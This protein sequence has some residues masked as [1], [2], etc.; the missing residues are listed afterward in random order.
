[1]P[2][3]IAFGILAC[4]ALAGSS[5]CSGSLNGQT[6][7]DVPAEPA[8]AS[9][10][11]KDRHPLAPALAWAKELKAGIEHNVKDYTAT[12]VKRERNKGK[13]GEE[14]V[15]NVKIRQQPFSVYCGVVAPNKGDE[16]IYLEGQNDGKM[17]CH[18]TGLIGKAFGTR[19]L[20]PDHPWVMEGQHYPITEIGVLNLCRRLIEVAEEDLKYD[21]CEV[22]FDRQAKLNNRSCTCVEV[23][24]PLP[25]KHFRFHL[26]RIYVDNE[27]KVPIRFEAFDW[28][29]SADAEPEMIESYEYRDLKLNVGL[30][31]ADFDVK[32]PEYQFP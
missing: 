27:L 18:T 24:H 17:I 7:S 15:I 4:L 11:P 14:N 20:R 30:T 22:K 6:G 19:A 2:I 21:E 26:A 3:R 5:G 16:A 12:M 9:L 29:K 23:S 28:P 25:R 1:M 32:N 13:L 10:V 31:D 8:E